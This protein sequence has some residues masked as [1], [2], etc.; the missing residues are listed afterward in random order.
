MVPPLPPFPPPKEAAPLPHGPQHCAAF[1]AVVS[2]AVSPGTLPTPHPR[3]PQPHIHPVLYSDKYLTGLCLREACGRV[4]EPGQT[5]IETID[6][7]SG[8]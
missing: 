2:A 1:S 3:A 5:A 4:R 8:K 7:M 6:Q